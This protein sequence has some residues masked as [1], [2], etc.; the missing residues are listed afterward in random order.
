VLFTT[1]D[2]TEVRA[3]HG[4]FTSAAPTLTSARF[5]CEP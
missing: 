4:Q 5:A 2:S 3:P 1:V